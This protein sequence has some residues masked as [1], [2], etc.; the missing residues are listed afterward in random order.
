MGLPHVERERHRPRCS[1]PLPVSRFE[2]IAAMDVA[3]YA[4][5][6]CALFLWAIDP[7][8]PQAYKLIA[9]W[10]F[11]YKTIGFYG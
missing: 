5:K 11:T 3:Q 6:D 9:A 2:T 4:A 7:L 1:R 8:L 10:G